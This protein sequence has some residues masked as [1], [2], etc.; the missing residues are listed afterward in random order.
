MNKVLKIAFFAFFLIGSISQVAAQKYGYVNSAAILAELPEVKAAEADLEAL[1]TQLR[2]KGQ[3]MVAQ[4][5]QDY[6]AL[7]Q[8]VQAGELSPQQQ[9]TEA[10]KLEKRQQEIGSFE[11]KMVADLQKKRNDLLEPIYDNVNEAIKTVAKEQGYIMIFDQQ[12]LLYAEET[13][14]IT[15]AVKAKL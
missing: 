10:G 8:K 4:F 1:Q 15:A 9:Q 7:E 3:D 14:D 12:V 13:Q 11:Q 6:Q 2:K 5:Q